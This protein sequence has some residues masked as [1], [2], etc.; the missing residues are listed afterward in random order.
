MFEGYETSG[1][2]FKEQQL[3]LRVW[4]AISHL[5]MGNSSNGTRVQSVEVKELRTTVPNVPDYAGLW[6]M[7]ELQVISPECTDVH[8]HSST[9]YLVKL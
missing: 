5:F 7:L 4:N 9:P 1:L 8:A 3:L 2:R 6:A